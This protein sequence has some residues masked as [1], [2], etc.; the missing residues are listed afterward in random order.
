MF[1]VE[2]EV[3]EDSKLLQ[4]VAIC[5]TVPVCVRR[6][7][8]CRVPLFQ[9]VKLY[10]FSCQVRDTLLAE[11]RRSFL[12]KCTLPSASSN[13]CNLVFLQKLKKRHRQGGKDGKPG[14]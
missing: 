3:T 9:L 8:D 1:Y 14:K 13:H 10:A 5:T 7:K 11:S 6:R 2:L 4:V 12:H